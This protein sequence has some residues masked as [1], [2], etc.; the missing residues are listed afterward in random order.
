MSE[1]IVHFVGNRSPSLYGTILIDGT[2][3]DLSGSTVKLQMRQVGADTL[4]VDSAAVIVT[5]AE[6]TVRYDWAAADVDTA[7]NYAAWWQITSASALVQ[8]TPEFLLEIREHAALGNEYV[9][10][11]ELKESLSLGGTTFAD[12]DLM[13]AVTAASRFVD[14][15]TGTQFY[16]GSAGEERKYTPI[17]EEYLLIDD[18]TDITEVTATDT[19]LVADTSYAE[20]GTPVVSVLRSL[21]GYRFPRGYVNSVAVTGTF[22]WPSPPAD[23]KQATVI[24]AARLLKRS[25]EAAFGVIGFDLDGGS[26]RISGRDPDVERLLA[27]YTRSGMIE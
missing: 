5:P 1:H 2:P 10:V 14:G 7:G 3:V 16:P 17:S 20:M 6:G 18:V 15:A 22:G 9:S 25:R 26:V 23:V 12:Q 21:N 11:A 13:L 8:D 24:L 4:D 19:V 27:P